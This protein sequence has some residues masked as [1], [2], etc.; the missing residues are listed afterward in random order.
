MRWY[1]ETRYRSG[2][3]LP[4]SVGLK[5]KTKWW[6]VKAYTKTSVHVI[7]IPDNRWACRVTSRHAP[8][9]SALDRTTLTE[10]PDAHPH[11]PRPLANARPS[12]YSWSTP[13]LARLPVWHHLSDIYGMSTLNCNGKLGCPR[14]VEIMVVQQLPDPT[15]TSHLSFLNWC[16]RAFMHVHLWLIIY[17]LTNRVTPMI[18]SP[19]QYKN[20]S[21]TTVGVQTRAETLRPVQPNSKLDLWLCLRSLLMDGR[22]F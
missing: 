7:Y 17:Y 21:A 8:G 20:L 15:F 6:L 19:E 4:F 16:V 13:S 12:C 5:R 10:L 1:V 2:K 3:F 11:T 9:H 14:Y 18:L 22:S